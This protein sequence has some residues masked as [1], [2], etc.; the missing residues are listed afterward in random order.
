VVESQLQLPRTP[1]WKVVLWAAG[2]VVL[3][4]GVIVFFVGRATEDSARKTAPLPA[5]PAQPAANEPD[6]KAFTKEAR[7]VARKFILTAV[8][9]KNTG[10]SW[11]LLDPTYPSKGEFTK[12]TWAQGNIPV[13]PLS[14]PLESLSQARFNVRYSSPKQLT[15]EVAFF[16][17]RRGG[18]KPELFEIGLRDRGTASKPRWLVDYWMT[19][20]VPGVRAEPE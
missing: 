18:R 9:R 3:A 12:R 19:R 6:Q 10:A 15:V 16:P 2:P 20:Y 5:L 4:V 14:F 7:E 1:W 8:V 11:E 13:I 17:G